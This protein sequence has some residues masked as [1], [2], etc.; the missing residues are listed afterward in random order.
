MTHLPNKSNDPDGVV[1]GIGEEADEH[2][3]L[4]VDLPGV[5]LVEERHHDERVEDHREVHRRRRVH[6]RVLPVVDVQDDVT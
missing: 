5:D 1:D 3:P 2:V 4:A 6:V